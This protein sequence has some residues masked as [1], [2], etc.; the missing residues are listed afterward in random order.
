MAY[1]GTTSTSPNP[2]R[3]MSQGITGFRTWVYDSTYIS[4]DISA[5]GFI[6]DAYYLGMKAADLVIAT[7]TT[8]GIITMHSV[9]TVTSTGASLSTGSTVGLGS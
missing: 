1:A 4:S 3:L 7:M 9:L 6:T 8:G 2:P 5:A